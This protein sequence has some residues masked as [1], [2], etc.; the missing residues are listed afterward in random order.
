MRGYEGLVKKTALMLKTGEHPD[1]HGKAP[2]EADLEDIEQLLRLKVMKAVQSFDP[3]RAKAGAAVKRGRSARDGYV[4][5]CLRDQA[6]DIAKKKRR[7]ELFIEDIAPVSFGDSARNGGSD[8]G[9]RDKFTERYLSA[10]HEE[11]FHDV[12][13]ELPVIPS[14]LS[15]RERLVLVLMYRSY[16]QTEIAV[17]LGITKREVE[18]AVRAIRSKM[19]DWRPS[20]Q[21]GGAG[22]PSAV[23]A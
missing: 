20:C 15:D 1:L 9:F 17:R 4:N 11:V 21:A 10:D 22:V 14:T 3:S 23:A 2:V 19:A 13:Q 8:M 6:K 7:G 16:R 12:E 18:S 5:M